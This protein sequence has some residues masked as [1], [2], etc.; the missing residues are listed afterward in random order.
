[1][2]TMPGPPAGAP[3]GRPAQPPPPPNPYPQNQYPPAYYPPNAYPG[4]FPGAV[5]ARRG[6]ARAVLLIV[7]VLLLGAGGVGAAV[8][9]SRSDGHGGGH[10][11]GNGPAAGQVQPGGS[12]G[13]EQG[14]PGPPQSGG[15]PAPDP[16]GG[17]A[18]VDGLCQT[19]GLA[20]LAKLVPRHGPLGGGSPTSVTGF[21][22]NSCRL[23]SLQATTPDD[24]YFR[25]MSLTVEWYGEVPGTDPPATKARG[26]LDR[27]RSSRGGQL[28]PG[29]RLVDAP[30]L[31]P[32]AFVLTEPLTD[33]PGARESVAASAGAFYVKVDYSVSWRHQVRP[34]SESTERDLAVG[35]V[36]TALRRLAG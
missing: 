20:E 9:A 19:V 16:R 36:R 15:G 2:S 3:W 4:A 1:V 12:G 31:G 35:L 13:G 21:A 25:D 8:L 7:V 30:E 26:D 27:E 5:P 6:N 34:V 10:N 14:D 29:G 18:R 17:E 22:I 32:G 28:K 11:G 24:G 33:E 23:D